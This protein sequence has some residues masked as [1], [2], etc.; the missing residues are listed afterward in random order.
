MHIKELFDLSGKVAVV[1]GGSIGLGFQMAKALAEAGADVVISARKEDRCRKAADELKT[2]GIRSLAVGADVA[3]P[4]GV[5]NLVERTVNEFGRL[6]IL[7]NNAGITWAAPAAEMSLKDWQKVLDVNITGTFLC[8]QAAGK[9]MISQGGGKIINLAS[10]AAFGGAPPEALDAIAYNTSKAAVVNFT[11]DLAVKWARHKIYVN[12]IAPG[13][14]PTHMS[15]Y[16]LESRGDMLRQSI[17]L[18]RWGGEDDLK[19]AV[20]FLASRASDYVTGQ[21]LS[22]DGGQTAMI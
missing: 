9:I 14:F 10:V 16:V 17:P 18:A 2:F 12:A 21:V 1:T 22:V 20:V 7:I 19:G 4:A 11:R 6:D 15:K 3:D 5:Q 8:S 13:W